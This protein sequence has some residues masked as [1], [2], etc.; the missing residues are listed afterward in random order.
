[1]VAVLIVVTFVE[2]YILSHLAIDPAYLVRICLISLFFTRLLIYPWQLVGLFRAIDRDFMAHRN[3]LK[4]RG[5]QAFALLTVLFTLAYSLDLIQNSFARKQQLEIYASP[6]AVVD[7]EIE[8]DQ[9]G[10]QL[11]IVGPLDIGITQAT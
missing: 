1:M 9:G 6:P 2:L 10:R 3:T 4:T 5:L 11:K 8:V 7:Y